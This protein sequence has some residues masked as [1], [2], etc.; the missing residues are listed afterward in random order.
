MT[1][2]GPPLRTVP[3]A[4]YLWRLHTYWTFAHASTGLPFERAGAKVARTDEDGD[5]VVV[6]D[7]G[8]VA[9]RSRG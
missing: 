1:A 6:V 7:A 2:A 5:V 3:A 8:G 9:V 4:V